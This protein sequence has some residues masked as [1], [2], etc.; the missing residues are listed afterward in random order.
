VKTHP[1]YARI[2]KAQA[3]IESALTALEAHP[4]AC[5]RTV[6]AYLFA[7]DSNLTAALTLIET[8]PRL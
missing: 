5:Q 7:A 2:I 3:A 4:A 8:D 1:A 6:T